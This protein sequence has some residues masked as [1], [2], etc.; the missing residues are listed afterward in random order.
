MP[1]SSGPTSFARSRKPPIP[2]PNSDMVLPLIQETPALQGRRVTVMGLGLFGGGLGVTRFLVRSGAKVTVTDSKSETDLRE[3]VEQ[4]R[5]LPVTFKF[6]GHDERDF[7]DAD[8]VIVNPAV[9]E[10]NAYLKL[11]R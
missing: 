9:P 4:L 8:L 6:G 1:S 7:R 5:G 11:P 3:S 2:S 10:T